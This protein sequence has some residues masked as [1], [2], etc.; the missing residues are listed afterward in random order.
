MKPRHHTHLLHIA[1]LL[2]IS[3][4]MASC[5][6]PEKNLRDETAPLE[7]TIEPVDMIDE[8]EKESEERLQIDPLEIPE[9]EELTIE[10]EEKQEDDGQLHHKK[11]KARKKSNNVV[12]ESADRGT[13]D[14][15]GDKLV[16]YKII[17]NKEL[18]AKTESGLFFQSKPAELELPPGR[19]LVLLE[20]WYLYE[21]EEQE[22]RE[23][24][25]ANNIWQMQAPVYIDIPENII[26]SVLYFGYDHDQRKF[27]LEISTLE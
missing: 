10:E 3:Y 24:R 18:A 22:V 25:R 15:S 26:E 20:R 6:A 5:T 14:P 4:S 11:R 13:T 16:Y 8:E 9:M 12:F 27:Y 21:S 17:L 2:L 23:Y 1:L 7:E 19:Y